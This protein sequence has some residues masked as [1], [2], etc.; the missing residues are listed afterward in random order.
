[1]YIWADYS[2]IGSYIS[3]GSLICSNL[4][5]DDGIIWRNRYILSQAIVLFVILT[6]LKLKILNLSGV[7]VSL[8]VLKKQ[9]AL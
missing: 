6:H 1:M 3:L 5:P 4:T 2:D 8:A 7:F 9:T